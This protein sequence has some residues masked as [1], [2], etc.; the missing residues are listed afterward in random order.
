[1][2]C[3]FS[4]DYSGRVLCVSLWNS[5]LLV[6]GDALDIFAFSLSDTP[7]LLT[8]FKGHVGPVTKLAVFMDEYLVSISDDTFLILWRLKN[9]EPIAKFRME[10]RISDFV[11]KREF[12]EGC[13]SITCVGE[14]DEV[15]KFYL[16][17]EKEEIVLEK[18]VAL[19]KNGGKCCCFGPNDEDIFCI[20]SSNGNITTV[21]KD[22]KVSTF[23]AHNSG[24]F[25]LTSSKT[26][27]FSGG[28]DGQVKK[29]SFDKDKNLVETATFCLPGERVMCLDAYGNDDV[30][31][32]SSGGKVLIWNGNNA[33][34]FQL[35]I[36]GIRSVCYFESKFIAGSYNGKLH[37][38][39]SFPTLKQMCALV[40][41]K[42]L[43]PEELRNYV[44]NV[45]FV[46][47]FVKLKK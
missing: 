43:V 14:Y 44:T 19:C 3:G 22:Q 2:D 15:T 32:G 41:Q 20:G 11:I 45:N 46:N 31:F 27:I 29:W 33:R 42:N 1:M 17:H 7:T 10:W 37:C 12:Q 8:R 30:I 16:K 5:V 26:N 23:K 35:S 38:L 6:G 34:I 36:G 13:F 47:S 24:V 40:V 25:C 18:K 21:Q 4:L 28:Y 9:G 39:F